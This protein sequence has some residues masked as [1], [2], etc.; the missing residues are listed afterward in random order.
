MTK[1]LTSDRGTL[2]VKEG[3]DGV[4]EGRFLSVLVK[5]EQVA[6]GKETATHTPLLAR[7]EASLATKIEL[8][9]VVDSSR[10]RFLETPSLFPIHTEKRT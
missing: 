8:G 2:G 7:S 9:P 4:K 1:N 3:H 5:V 6:L 10:N